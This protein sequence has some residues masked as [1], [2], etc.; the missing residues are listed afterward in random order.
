MPLLPIDGNSLT[1]SLI[2]WSRMLYPLD[3]EKYQRFIS[4]ISASH[5]LHSKES[6]VSINTTHLNHVLDSPGIDTV[7]REAETQRWRGVFS[8][9]VL[10]TTL[11]LKQLN[12]KP[13]KNKA[14]F[15]VSKTY[16]DIKD[17][18]SKDDKKAK[19]F[20]RDEKKD[21]EDFVSVAHFWAAYVTLKDNDLGFEDILS[22][23]V[24][25]LLSIGELFRKEAEPFK[26]VGS[27]T[28][29]LNPEKTWK[30]PKDYPLPEVSLEYPQDDSEL[31]K[32]IDSY[33]LK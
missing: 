33:K 8:G 21:W 23:K 20:R 12:Y 27:S 6:S 3:E 16:S 7:L 32:I 29:L 22:S 26:A 18:F 13:H 30:V 19:A 24:E 2:V 15:A 5:L 25:T 10:L 1:D 28:T 11:K 4:I 14:V 17:S 31:K 9:R